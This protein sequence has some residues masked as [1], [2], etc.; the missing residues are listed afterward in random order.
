MLS[1][2]LQAT[3]KVEAIGLL[4]VEETELNDIVDIFFEVAPMAIDDGDHQWPSMI[5]THVRPV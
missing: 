1:S 3:W 4:G 2:L 5:M